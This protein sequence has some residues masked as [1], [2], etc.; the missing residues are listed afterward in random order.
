NQEMPCFRILK[1]TANVLPQLMN[2]ELRSIQDVIRHRPD[3][4][5]KYTLSRNGFQYGLIWID[6]MRPTRLAKPADEGGIRRF[7]KPERHFYGSILLQLLIDGGKLIE[8]LAFPN[9]HDERSFRRA[10]A[11]LDY[12]FMKFGEEFQREVIYAE[13]TAIFECPKKGSLSGTAK[14]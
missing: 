5:Q 9:V 4:R 12:Q 1:K 3:R 13:V 10:L 6:R 11:G 2:R 8:V 7:Q 14:P